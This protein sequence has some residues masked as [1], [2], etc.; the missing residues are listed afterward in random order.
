MN[1]NN[2]AKP[3]KATRVF[4]DPSKALAKRTSALVFVPEEEGKTH[5]CL[6]GYSNSDIGRVFSPRYP[7]ELHLEGVP[8]P[9]KTVEAALIQL[10]ALSTG[11]ESPETI[12][13]LSMMAGATSKELTR[14]VKSLP[15]QLQH[16][17]YHSKRA[18]PADIVN[19][20]VG[21]LSSAY[22]AYF[23]RIASPIPELLLTNKLPYAAYIAKRD[24]ADKTKAPTIIRAYGRDILIDVIR[25]VTKAYVARKKQANK[26]LGPIGVAL[27]KAQ[28][29]EQVSHS[30]VVGEESIP[31]TKERVQAASTA[32][33]GD[34]TPCETE[35]AMTQIQSGLQVSQ[36]E[37]TGSPQLSL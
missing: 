21:I 4:T 10:I 12:T 14:L 37:D 18:L 11:K 34:T 28:D 36:P 25:A 15:E 22:V 27:R 24:P 5:I 8:T 26:P 2:Q 19:S 31:V 16:D 23:D 9:F 35:P 33:Q 13:T 32:L 17:Y 29:K 3:R 1:K 7:V 30:L 20:I 6:E